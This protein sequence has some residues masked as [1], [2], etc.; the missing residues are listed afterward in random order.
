[1]ARSFGSGK[2]AASSFMWSTVRSTSTMRSRFQFCRMRAKCSSC[3]L[4]MYCS[5]RR[6]MYGLTLRGPARRL[7]EPDSSPSSSLGGMRVGMTKGRESN[8]TVGGALS[9]LAAGPLVTAD[10]SFAG[11][12][13][14]DLGRAGEAVLGVSCLVS[15]LT[16]VGFVVGLCGFTVTFDVCFKPGDARAAFLATTAVLRTAAFFGIAFPGFFAALLAFFEG[17]WCLRLQRESARLYRRNT[18]CTGRRHHCFLGA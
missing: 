8:L 10:T 7:A 13:P 6:A 9:A 17:I 11:A 12:A 5:P 14:G 2:L 1:M 15:C 16:G 18:R 4:L 3:S